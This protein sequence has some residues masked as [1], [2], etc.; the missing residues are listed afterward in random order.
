VQKEAHVEN[1]QEEYQKWNGSK[2]DS[3]R[4]TAFVFLTSTNASKIWGASSLSCGRKDYICSSSQTPELD[5][6]VLINTLG[7]QALIKYPMH[8]KPVPHD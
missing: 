5:E 4:S 1:G 2:A 7:L 8:S 3:F 6:F